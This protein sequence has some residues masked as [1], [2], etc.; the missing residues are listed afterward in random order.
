MRPWAPAVLILVVLAVAACSNGPSK[1]VSTGPDV[2]NGGAQNLGG[3]SSQAGTSHGTT[4]SGDSGKSGSKGST[5][6][7]SSGKGKSSKSGSKSGSTGSKGSSGNT[8]SSSGSSSSRSGITS[9][10]LPGATQPS[11]VNGTIIPGSELNSR[12][13]ST[14]GTTSI[15]GGTTSGGGSTA[16]PSPEPN[17]DANL[18]A[19]K[20][21][22]ITNVETGR[23]DAAGAIQPASTFSASTDTNV[24]AGVTMDPKVGVTGTV[25]TYVVIYGCT[26]EPSS[27]YTLPQ[28]LSGFYV[29]FDAST[30]PFTPGIYHIRFFVNNVAAWDAS[31]TITA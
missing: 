16:P 23:F 20:S 4:G 13:G 6:S 10:L 19:V 14:G 29:Q 21:V 31:Y 15:G 22:G 27:S 8:N 26:Y 7:Q 28:Q 11:P 9:V 1:Q 2:G 17:C 12:P 5:S 30:T 24:V 3:G 18:P 25:V